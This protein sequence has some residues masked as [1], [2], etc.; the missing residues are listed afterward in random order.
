MRTGLPWS[1]KFTVN[2]AKTL[3]RCLP[4]ALCSRI[5]KCP[6]QNKLFKRKESKTKEVCLAVTIGMITRKCQTTQYLSPRSPKC[7]MVAGWRKEGLFCYHKYALPY[8]CHASCPLSATGQHFSAG[9]PSHPLRALCH[10]PLL[11]CNLE[12]GTN[13]PHSCPSRQSLQVASTSA[14]MFYT[15]MGPF[16]QEPTWNF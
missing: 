15:Y 10:S 1:C 9:F 4:G 13:C 16:I 2:P 14:E 3:T 11:D 12:A 8:N 5:I 6:Q 7:K